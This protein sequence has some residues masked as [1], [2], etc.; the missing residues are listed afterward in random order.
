MTH[1]SATILMM[2]EYKHCV[3]IWNCIVLD[4]DEQSVRW[5]WCMVEFECGITWC[6]MHHDT[7]AIAMANTLQWQCMTHER[8]LADVD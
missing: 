3:Y 6:T 4:L 1:D 2:T 5:Y 7:I 8:L